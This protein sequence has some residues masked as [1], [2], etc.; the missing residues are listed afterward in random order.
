MKNF[1]WGILIIGV[2][3]FVMWGSVELSIDKDEC[4]KSCKM[5]KSRR[6]DQ[7]C[8]CISES[9]WERIN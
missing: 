1:L 9:G 4:A 2:L 7:Q 5:L 6:I 3:L 8:Y